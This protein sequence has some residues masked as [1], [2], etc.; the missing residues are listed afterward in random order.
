[1]SH[2]NKKNFNIQ[3]LVSLVVLLTFFAVGC[4]K[5]TDPQSDDSV[6]TENADQPESKSVSAANS[7]RNAEPI[8]ISGQKLTIQFIAGKRFSPSVAVGF[9]GYYFC[10]EKDAKSG[11]FVEDN[12]T[13]ERKFRTG[14]WKIA[15]DKAVVQY[16]TQNL[17]IGIGNFSTST[18]GNSYHK[19][20]L[21]TEKTDKKAEFTDSIFTYMS[22]YDL[23][24]GCPTYSPYKKISKR[25][26]QTKFDIN[27]AAGKLY[28]QKSEGND[29]NPFYHN[30][31]YLCGEK[32][33]SSGP[34]VYDVQE[35]FETPR[36]F[37]S[38]TWK[39]SGNRIEVNY[40][41]LKSV[42]ML[43]TSVQNAGP[44]KEKISENMEFTEEKLRSARV[45]EYKEK[46]PVFHNP[47]QN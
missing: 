22:A 6:S 18:H 44:S 33:A 29:D 27:D 1:M 31:L 17:E 30:E 20:A 11:T 45:F 38:G 7:D 8:D 36:Q 19:Y 12:D 9:M 40:S 24:G 16:T 28:L 23:K 13:I 15:G 34:A 25:I 10:G 43:D 39:L 32:G 41:D 26:T 47:K 37:K 2:Q 46:C 14:T 42:K 4:K 35:S 21:Y 3:K 5:G